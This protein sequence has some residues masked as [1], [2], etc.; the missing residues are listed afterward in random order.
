MVGDMEIVSNDQKLRRRKERPK[1]GRKK[2]AGYI[3][4]GKQEPAAP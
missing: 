3:N 4:I 1:K 2:T